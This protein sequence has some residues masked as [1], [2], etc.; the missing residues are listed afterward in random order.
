MSQ[1][2]NDKVKLDLLKFG[3]RD[4]NDCFNCGNC[5]A[6][7]KLTEEGFLFPRKVIKQAQLGLKDSMVANLDPWLCYYCGECSESCPRDANPG[8]I[9]MSM[10]RYLT[11]LYDWTGLSRK[12]YTSKFWEMGVVALFFLLVIAAFAL[13]LPPDPLIFTQAQSFVNEQGGV[14]INSL[15]SGVTPDQFVRVIE[16]SDWIMALIIGGILISNIVRMFILSIIRDKKYKIPW[17]AYFTEAWSLIYHF[18]TQNKFYHCDRRRYWFGHF[19]LMSGYTMMF[20]FIVVL[21]K[22]FQ[23]E[24]IHPWYHWQRLLGYYA[25]FGILLFLGI[26]TYQRI[27][28][29]DYKFM[30]SHA[31][32][33]LFIVM[34]GLTTVSGIVLHFFRI[35]GMPAAT[36]ITYV[37]HMAILV[38][39]IIIEVP[40]SKW[41]HLAYRPFAIYFYKLKKKARATSPGYQASFTTA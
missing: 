12:F 26:A 8:E 37:I 28:R 39:M 14:M 2:V 1:L 7:C 30:Y 33:W 35:T 29:T 11:S 18:V 10:R 32:D 23:T 25:T 19:L 36:Y 22:E 24:Q 16:Y 38:P 21:L 15:V 3:V 41:S 20:I 40:F 5:T 13:F 4:W 6:I 9:M 27:K 17:W 34:L 31:S